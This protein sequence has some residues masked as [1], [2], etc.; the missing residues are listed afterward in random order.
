MRRR[1][2]AAWGEALR[3]VSPNGAVAPTAA[4]S[5]VGLRIRVLRA[6]SR[7]SR[8]RERDCT[9]PSPV[10]ELTCRRSSAPPQRRVSGSAGRPGDRRA[11][12]YSASTPCPLWT[13]RPPGPPASYGSR[14]C[15]PPVAPRQARSRARAPP[16]QRRGLTRLRSRRSASGI[17]WV[18]PRTPGSTVD[19]RSCSKLVCDQARPPS[20]ARESRGTGLVAVARSA[21]APSRRDPGRCHA[22]V[23]TRTTRAP[24]APRARCPAGQERARW[25]GCANRS[26]SCRSTRSWNLTSSRRRRPSPRLALGVLSIARMPTRFASCRCPTTGS[27]AT[28]GHRA[29]RGPPSFLLTVVSR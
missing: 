12:S 3:H 20:A 4:A 9:S 28:R 19:H 17:R 7:G 14:D 21:V 2:R 5:S 8:T 25:P 1:A 13:Q 16:S 10:P 24:D 6:V 26:R 18:H 27:L 15:V 11:G 23:S 22:G 29:G